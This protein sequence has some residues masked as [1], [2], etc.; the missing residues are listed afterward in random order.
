MFNIY[1]DY[2]NIIYIIINIYVGEPDEARS[3]DP[4][5]NKKK[6]RMKTEY[7]DMTRMMVMMM[8]LLLMMMIA[9]KM[10]P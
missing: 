10:K 3:S 5:H 6:K 8:L 9:V 4:V 1:Y 7:H 2:Y